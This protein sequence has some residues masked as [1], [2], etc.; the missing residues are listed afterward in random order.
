MN[1][2]LVLTAGQTDVQIVTD[3]GRTEF[4]KRRCGRL[5]AELEDRMGQWEVR[6]APAIKAPGHIQALPP[7]PFALCTPKLDAV[8]EF[9]EQRNVTLTH[10]LILETRRDP[11]AASGDPRAAGLVLAHRLRDQCGDGLVIQRAPFLE[12]CERIEDKDGDPRDALIRRDVIARIDRAI[13]D[14]VCKV[15]QGRVVVA[16]TGG[17]PLIATLT[18]EV[19]RLHAGSFTEVELIEVADGA[20]ANPP[21]GDRAVERL[22]LPEPSESYK[23]RRHALELIENGN[24]LAAWGAVSHLHDDEVEHDWTQVVEWVFH[25]ASSLPIPQECDM[26]ILRHPKMAVRAALRVEFALQ[27]KNVPRAVHGTVAFYE[28]ALWDHLGERVERSSDPQRSRQFR[29]RKG[30]SAPDPRLIRTGDGSKEDRKRPFEPGEEIDGVT[31]YW[32]H[33]NEPCAG[34]LTKN[35]LAKKALHRLGRAISQVRDLRN[36]VAHNE[37][38]P[39]LMNDAFRRMVEASLWSQDGMFLAQPLVQDALRE[40]EVEAPEDLRNALTHEI[41][42]RLTE[43]PP[44]QRRRRG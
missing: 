38:T 16:A 31:W 5:H 28:A 41:R 36:D 26:T 15:A 37:P 8:L 27:A 21:T 19:V 1:V 24:L 9:L 13:R 25:F 14:A 32:I 40:L 42:S 44:Q 6:D 30:V 4:E 2:L 20:K 7:R 29:I 12:G 34:Q 3:D 39:D 35:F 18:E 33:D 10:A 17:M 11:T 22:S 43:P 23:A